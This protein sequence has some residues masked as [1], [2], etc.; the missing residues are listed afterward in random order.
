MTPKVRSNHHQDPNANSSTRKQILLSAVKSSSLESLK[1]LLKLDDFRADDTWF[2]YELLLTAFER[3]HKS[4]IKFLLMKN[5]RVK[6]ETRTEASTPLHYAVKMSDLSIVK[7]LLRLN[8]SIL[9]K[10]ENQE[11]PFDLAVK[12]RK[13]DMV[14][15]MLLMYDFK[16]EHVNNEGKMHCF[17]YACKTDNFIAIQKFID[18]G[19]PINSH[20]GPRIGECCKGFTPLHFAVYHESLET[21]LYLLKHKAS[22]IE[23]NSKGDTPLNYAFYLQPKNGDIIDLLL[24]VIPEDAIYADSRGLSHFHIACT[25][26]DLKTVELF[27]Q[28]GNLVDLR[29]KSD[30]YIYSGYTPLH[31]AVEYNRF[32]LVKALL[33]NG[34]NVNTKTSDGKT[35]LHIA[36]THSSDKW[37]ELI[38]IEDLD[39]EACDNID[40]ISN[41][42]DQI[43]I[44]HL[45]LNYKADVN[46]KDNNDETPL[47]CAC[48]ISDDSILN[49]EQSFSEQREHPVYRSML[50]EINQRILEI[51][52]I[53]LNHNADIHTCTK[54]DHDSVLHLIIKSTMEH[55]I[56]LVKALLNKGLKLHTVDENGYSPLHWA[57]MNNH[58]KDLVKLFLDH[59]ADINARSERLATPLHLALSHKENHEPIVNHLL[60]NGADVN[61]RDGIDSTP[62][63]RAVGYFQNYQVIKQ[64]LQYGADINLQDSSGY[65]GAEHFSLILGSDGTFYESLNILQLF[66]NHVE[67]LIALGFYVKEE[68]IQHLQYMNDLILENFGLD[69]FEPDDSSDLCN[70]ELEKLKHFKIDG[71]IDLYSILLKNE[72]EMEKLVEDDNLVYTLASIDESNFPQY[73]C[74]LKLQLVKGIKRA[75]LTK[76]ALDSLKFLTDLDRSKLCI[77]HISKHFNKEDINSL[78]KT[79]HVIVSSNQ[80]YTDLFQSDES[81]TEY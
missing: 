8:A 73:G 31:L 21:I 67:K 64:L 27:L 29:I 25:R 35:A 48:K 60:Q 55:S 2:D 30:E 10:D 22:V 7:R 16:T 11:T 80:E 77:D 37:Y 23:K 42:K 32:D 66:Q 70:K 28:C 79:G 52:Q 4:L 63:H 71:S 72:E 15:A 51:V 74:L 41:R 12:D 5:C 18:L 19:F 59:N 49:H 3:K 38:D 76:P 43:S 36:C 69:C 44:I 9:D 58:N 54:E 46:A 53:L 39:E 13:Y 34:A 45:L 24:K 20:A 33:E 14:E 50:K 56:E 61:A 26:N 75:I 47:I 17:H 65:T 68:V 6:R 81:P 57:A 62:L 40:W 78:V 1:K